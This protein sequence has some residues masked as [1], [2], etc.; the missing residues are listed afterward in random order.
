MKKQLIILALSTSFLLANSNDI[1]LLKEVTNSKIS[2]T[3]YE[4]NSLT[5]SKVDGG[6]WTPVRHNDFTQIYNRLT[7]INQLNKSSQRKQSYKPQDR[8]GG[9]I[10]SSTSSN[11]YR[12]NKS[13]ADILHYEQMYNGNRPKIVSV[14]DLDNYTRNFNSMNIYEQMRLDKL[15]NGPKFIPVPGKNYMIKNPNYHGRF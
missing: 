7:A 4:L 14:T 2:G 3:Q 10:S 1:D 6:Y 5:M 13:I 12:N 11:S 8:F 9:S 15:F